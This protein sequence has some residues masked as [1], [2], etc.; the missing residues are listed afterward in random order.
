MRLARTALLFFALACAS[1]RPL[2]DREQLARVALPKLGN[3]TMALADLRGRVV[4]L[5]FWATWCEPC[6]EALPFYVELQREL[7][8]RGFTVAAVSVDSGDD[9][10]VRRYFFASGGP[11]LLILRDRDGQLAERLGV[12]IMPTS[13][14]LDRTGSARFRLEGFSAGDRETIRSRILSLLENR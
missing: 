6:K 2:P 14:L 7:A 8:A 4:L 9:E 11:Q 12:Q 3:G 1:A 13:F 5:D 10:S